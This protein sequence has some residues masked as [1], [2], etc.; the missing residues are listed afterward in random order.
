[1]SADRDWESLGTKTIYMNRKNCPE[2]LDYVIP[3]DIHIYIYLYLFI[4]LLVKYLATYCRWIM[5]HY[6]YIYISIIRIV[7][8]I[9]IPE[10]LNHQ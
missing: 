4:Y 7:Y 9:Q 2:N 3:L 1:M 8:P 5:D 10:S 6:I